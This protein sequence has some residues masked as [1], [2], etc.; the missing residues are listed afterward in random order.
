MKLRHLRRSRSALFGFVARLALF[1]FSMTFV[2]PMAYAGQWKQVE[3]KWHKSSVGSPTDAT[4]IYQRDTVKTVVAASI[5]DTTGVFSLS[6]AD[7]WPGNGMTTGN[8]DTLVVGYLVMQAD[9]SATPTS[10]V[11]SITYEID[12]RHGGFGVVTDNQQGWT[13]VDSL[14]A[15]LVPETGI[16]GGTLTVPILAKMGEF[17]TPIGSQIAASSNW[18]RLASY[19]SLRIRITATTGILSAARAWV[20]YWDED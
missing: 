7:V 6:N 19:E 16:S 18:L 15:T 5:L 17:I 3:V 10:S 1:A 8:V 2:A 12:G 13:Q 4:A 9:T 20:R 14:V 11:T